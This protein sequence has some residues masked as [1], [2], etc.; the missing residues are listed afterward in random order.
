MGLSD[1]G[2][3]ETVTTGGSTLQT[4]HLLQEFLAVVA[5]LFDE[6]S[7]LV[8]ADSMMSGEVLDF[9]VLLVSHVATTPRIGFRLVVCHGD[10][11]L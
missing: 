10:A 1:S 9:M 2:M 3:G 6:D 4:R 5:E 11:L 8:N 7:R